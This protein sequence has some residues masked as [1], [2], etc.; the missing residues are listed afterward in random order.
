MIFSLMF[1][2]QKQDIFSILSPLKFLKARKGGSTTF[3]Y[4]LNKMNLTNDPFQG[5]L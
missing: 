1:L 3:L 5:S 4:I 2:K